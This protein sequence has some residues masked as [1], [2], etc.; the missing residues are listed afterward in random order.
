MANE[1]MSLIEELQNPPRV[2]GGRL[3]ESKT[4]DVMKTAAFALSTMIGVAAKASA[5]CEPIDA[6]TPPP[7]D[8]RLL[9]WFIG[10]DAP[11]AAQCWTTGIISSHRPGFV[12]RG[13][14]YSPV[15]WFTHWVEMPPAPQFY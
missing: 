14:G 10:A 15:E 1:P 13:D 6:N 2:D 8:E 4:I 11:K 3:D 9:L 12:F 7:L 5:Q